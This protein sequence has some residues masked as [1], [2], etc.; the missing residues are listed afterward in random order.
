MLMLFGAAAEM[1]SLGA[2]FP[3]LAILS[4]KQQISC[5]VPII[6]CQMS[7]MEVSTLFGALVVVTAI[8]RIVLLYVSNRFTYAL[9]A[10]IGNELYRRVL[11]QPYRFH[12]SRNT[13][14][15]IAS[16]SKVNTVVQQ[17][18]NPLL[19]GLVALTI[20]L[21]IFIML[22]HIDAVIASVALCGFGLLYVLASILSRKRLYVNSKIISALESKRIK[23][24]QEGMGGIRDVIIDNSQ[25]IYSRRFAKINGEQRR[26]QAKSVIIRGV[27]RY[28]IEGLGMLV[29]I[30][31]AWMISN[32]GS[33]SDTIPVLGALA[34][35]AQKLLPQLQQI[36]AAW[37]AVTA[38]HAMLTDV[39][40][41][42]DMEIPLEQAEP[43]KQLP[44]LYF[45]A[46]LIALKN[47]SF[48]YSEQSPI[49]LED[50]NIEIHK[51][52]RIGFVGKTGSGKS[53]LIDLIMGLM[54]PVGGNIEIEGNVLCA[55]NRRSWQAR[56]AHVPQSIFLSDASIA[57]N[58][59]FGC[60]ADTLNIEAVKAAAGK[61]EMTDFI[62]SLD[63]G[64]WTHVGER[65]IRLSG[66]QRQRIAL[67]RAL[68]KKADIMILDEAT[69]ALDDSTEESV[70]KSIESLGIGI[71]VLL[72]AHRVTTLKNCDRIYEVSGKKLS[73]KNYSEITGSDLGIK[74]KTT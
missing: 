41:L 55:A 74:R 15:I 5:K 47:L 58:I 30:W 48:G 67:A 28:V 37:G 56:I 49:I 60:D 9:G 46:P 31:L 34:L 17:I 20:A 53:T 51:G 35:G 64:Y 36:Y 52:E 11:F 68:Y 21:G 3:F 66:G 45:N 57:E 13:S 32:R 42:L 7:L 73:I 18:I 29:V 59:A 1:L 6:S 65:G 19:Q 2:V 63:N 23:S 4:G 27:P 38:N 50:I 16:I 54:E 12:V 22:F 25:M 39:L 71:T 44:P 43:V 26:A 40:D 14:V 70:M 24:I 69:S 8:V 10:D 61:A 33:T 62:E 72:I